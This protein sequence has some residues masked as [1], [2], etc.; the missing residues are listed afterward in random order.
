MIVEYSG[1][2]GPGIF[3][4][5]GGGGVSGD[6][7]GVLDEIPWF[8]GGGNGFSVSEVESAGSVGNH[9][10]DAGKYYATMSGMGG[11][12]SSTDTAEP[13]HDEVIGEIESALYSLGRSLRQVRLHEFLLAEA[14][15]DIDQAG[16]AVLYVLNAEGTSLRLTDLAER[17]RIDAPAV[18]RKAQQLERWGLVSRARD[19]EDGRATRLQLTAQGCQTIGRFLAARRAWLTSLLAGW[20]EGEQVEF[21]RLL[22]QFTSDIHRHLGE[23]DD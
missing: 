10:L 6:E 13:V 5:H 23:L 17:L 7:F 16:M 12:D 3:H 19:R 18:T 4:D 9:L 15:V 14:R 1:H 11:E 22:R 8:S 21:G 20:P 2:R